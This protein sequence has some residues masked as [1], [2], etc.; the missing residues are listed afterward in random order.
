MVV[1][2]VLVLAAT[3]V[4]MEDFVCCIRN[5]HEKYAD[6]RG[7][8]IHDFSRV[9]TKTNEGQKNTPTKYAKKYAEFCAL[10]RV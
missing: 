6:F 10:E 9:R 5:T 8:S 7:C 4:V 2:L 1:M 3:L